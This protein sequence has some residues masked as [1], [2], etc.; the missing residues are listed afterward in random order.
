MTVNLSSIQPMVDL[1]NHFSSMSF[2]PSLQ[3]KGTSEQF[4]STTTSGTWKLFVIGLLPPDNAV[5]FYPIL[6]R[7]ADIPLAEMPPLQWKPKPSTKAKNNPRGNSVE[8]KKWTS[9]NRDAFRRTVIDEF[10]RLNGGTPPSEELLSLLCAHAWVEMGAPR[11]HTRSDGTY[12]RCPVIPTLNYNIGGVHAGA[13]AKKS[14]TDIPGTGNNVFWVDSLQVTHEFKPDGTPVNPSDGTWA[15]PHN[16]KL[17]IADTSDSANKGFYDSLKS[18]QNKYVDVDTQGGSP[19]LVAFRSH[20]TM[21]GGVASWMSLLM[22]K[23]PGIKTAKDANGYAIALLNGTPNKYGSIPQYYDKS[24]GPS[25]TGGNGH[26]ARSLELQQESYWNEYPPTPGIT[27]NSADAVPNIDP[28]QRILAYGRST[29]PEDP[30]GPVFGRNIQADND[31]FNQ[32]QARLQELSAS[33]AQMSQIPPLAMLVNPQE[34]RKNH[35]QSID[36]GVKT[37]T[38]NVV[39]T[40]LEQPIKMNVN[41]VSAAQYAIY[42]D[43]SGGLTTCNRIHSLSYRNLMSLLLTYKNNGMIYGW[44]GQSDGSILLAG[45]VFIIYDDHLYIGSFD[46]FSITDDA[47]KP[48]NLSYSF[49]FTVR[50]DMTVD[51]GVDAQLASVS[52]G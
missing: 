18:G 24:L 31:R 9:M 7:P 51:I 50:F 46:N 29:D 6:R 2:H 32:I 25:E 21:E 36:F 10:A 42:A 5:N 26:Y 43:M 16:G 23:Y 30:L 13:G 47:S 45:S 22:N 41:G 48:F 20:G 39:H 4:A 15:R 1:L 8:N 52:T 27:G 12:V 33:I 14:E 34:L 28:N 11:G 35:E 38:G 19:Y 17:I 44:P 40:W 37:R 3:M 49:S